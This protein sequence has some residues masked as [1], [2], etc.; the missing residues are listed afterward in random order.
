MKN[1]CAVTQMKRKCEKLQLKYWLKQIGERYT[2]RVKETDREVIRNEFDKR[3]TRMEQ[4]KKNHTRIGY[5][6]RAK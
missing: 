2:Q 6:E 5:C 4:A 3:R 1:S